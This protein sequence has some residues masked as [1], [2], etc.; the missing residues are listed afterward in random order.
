[1]LHVEVRG[2]Y[3]LTGVDEVKTDLDNKYPRGRVT[4]H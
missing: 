2:A 4:Y 1:M 3:P